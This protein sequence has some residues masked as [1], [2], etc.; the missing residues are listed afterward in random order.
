MRADPSQIEQ[1]ILNLAVNARDA[2]PGGGQL[3]LETGNAELATEYAE[4]HPEIAPGP[5]VMLAVSDT[6]HG[7][8]RQTQARIFEPF[9]TTKEKGRGTGLGLATVHDIVKQ[10]GGSIFVYSEPGKGTTFKIYFPRVEDPVEGSLR[11]ATRAGSL[12]GTE[13]VLVVDDD[14]AIRK[15]VHRVLADHGY[16]V[17]DAIS[18]PEALRFCERHA[19][20]VHLMVTDAIMPLM[21][22]RELAKRASGLRPRMKVVYMSGYTGDA[23]IHHGLLEPGSAFIEKPFTPESILRKVRETL[24]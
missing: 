24:D 4:L 23:A 22:G 14:D 7:M 1:I 11:P 6:G 3:T 21:D 17:L 19:G 18:S 5:H 20:P 2:M 9:F 16:T 12:R 15:L 10:N 13:T 8:D